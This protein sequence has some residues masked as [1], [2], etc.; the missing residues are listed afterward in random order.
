M[1]LDKFIPVAYAQTVAN[2]AKTGTATSG[3]TGVTAVQKMIEFIVGHIGLWI[4]GLVIILVAYVASKR[5]ATGI[6][7]RVIEKRGDDVQE[8]LLVLIDRVTGWC[9]VGLGIVIALAI[10]GLNFAA[11]VGAFSLGIGFA[12]KDVIS[13]FI[14]SIMMLA[15]SYIRIGDLIEINGIMGTVNQINTRVSIITTLDGQEVLIPNQTLLTSNVINYSKN[16]FRRINIVI[17]VD[18]KTDLHMATSLIRGVIYK[19]PDFV[20][21][22]APMVVIDEFA[23]SAIQIR[24]FA[25]IESNKSPFITRSN[26]AYRIKKAFDE[27]KI[28]IPFNITTFKIDEDDRAFLKTMES[29][30]KGYV[31]ESA[32]TPTSDEI[33]FAAEKTEKLEKI[34]YEI[35]VPPTPAEKQGLVEP[36]AVTAPVVTDQNVPMAAPT[37]VPELVGVGAGSDTPAM[38]APPS[39][40]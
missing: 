9:V 39:H 29:Y 30:K 36:K 33:K 3:E 11:V 16:P 21:K 18:Y 19:D 22:P 2:A 32:R 1:F 10:N 23:S 27:C 24:V 38:K 34:P 25:W 26:L 31:P 15:Q 17:G 20:P 4:A 28:N 12:L 6:K 35:F 40:M 14:S 37:P 13:N 5:V 8:N 7:N